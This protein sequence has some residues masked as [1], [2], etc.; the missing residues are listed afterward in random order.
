[1][2]LRKLGPHPSPGCWREPGLTPAGPSRR[3]GR[4]KRAGKR[5]CWH[6]IARL[7]RERLPDSCSNKT[8]TLG[9]LF[10]QT[11]CPAPLPAAK[12]HTVIR[13]LPRSLGEDSFRISD[14]VEI[15][16]KETFQTIYT[17]PLYSRAPALLPQPA[18][19]AYDPLR[20]AWLTQPCPLLECFRQVGIALESQKAKGTRDVLAQVNLHCTVTITEFCVL[21]RGRPHTPVW[22][23]RSAGGPGTEGD[24][25]VEQGSSDSPAGPPPWV[26]NLSQTRTRLYC[27]RPTLSTDRVTHTRL[28]RVPSKERVW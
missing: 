7:H 22:P 17:Y 19:P 27:A 16:V 12:I 15:H 26:S 3:K 25:D 28:V 18:R 8:V 24:C 13:F 21:R 11:E 1:M 5:A 14:W 6:E 10:Y 23:G 9:D 4:S 2:T 20:G